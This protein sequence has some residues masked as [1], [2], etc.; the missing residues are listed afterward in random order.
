MKKADL[1]KSGA[2]LSLVT[3]DNGLSLDNTYLKNYIG[4]IPIN[5]VLLC[6]KIICAYFIAHY[7]IWP[8]S[9][10]GEP[11]RSYKE[12]YRLALET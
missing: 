9:W 5:S 2:S 3:W 8:S 6:H 7:I 11:L 12:A 4:L 1:S 10:L